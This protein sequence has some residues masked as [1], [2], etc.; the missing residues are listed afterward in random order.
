MPSIL[1]ENKWDHSYRKIEDVGSSNITV[2]KGQT[3]DRFLTVDYD[4]MQ[5]E[6]EKLAFEWREYKLQ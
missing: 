1:N 3:D 5:N 2:V 6:T 4:Y